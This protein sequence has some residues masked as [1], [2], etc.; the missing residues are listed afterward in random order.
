MRLYKSI[1]YNNIYVFAY[2]D[3][4]YVDNSKL[5]STIDLINVIL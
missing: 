5:L 1:N 2:I 3:K 4:Q